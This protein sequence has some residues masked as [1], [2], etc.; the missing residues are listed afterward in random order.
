MKSDIIKSSKRKEEAKMLAEIAIL[1]LAVT[2]LI[3]VRTVC[4]LLKAKKKK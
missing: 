1:V 3:L 2:N 4:D